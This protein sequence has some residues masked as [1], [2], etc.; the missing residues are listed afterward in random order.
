MKKKYIYNYGVV[1]MSRLGLI[2]LSFVLF[3]TGSTFKRTCCRDSNCSKSDGILLEVTLNARED[4]V[5]R[6]YVGITFFHHHFIEYFHFVF[7]TYVW[8]C[9]NNACILADLDPISQTWTP[10]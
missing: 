6:F 1:V 3:L 5:R 7:L 2:F 4:G 9:I 8:V 10:V